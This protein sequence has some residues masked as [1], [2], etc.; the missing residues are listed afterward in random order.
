MWKVTQ[1]KVLIKW[2]KNSGHVPAG[3]LG[4]LSVDPCAEGLRVRFLVGEHIETTD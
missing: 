1:P 3:W 2:C 4:W